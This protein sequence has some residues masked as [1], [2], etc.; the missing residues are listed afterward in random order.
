MRAS[1]LIRVSL[2]LIVTSILVSG[3]HMARA[4]DLEPGDGGVGSG[5]LAAV[6]DGIRAA[7]YRVTWQEQTVLDDLDAAWHAP[8]RAHDL[9]T[10]FTPDG[11]RIV[12]RTEAMPGWHLGL[13]LT[14][15]GGPGSI[16]AL[17]QAILTPEANRILCDHGPVTGQWVNGE[18]GLQ[19]VLTVLEPGSAERALVMSTQSSAWR[20]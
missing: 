12:P 8:N 2:A 14:G 16:Q 17:E 9:R 7:E 5:W 10:Y 4:G 6:E 11:V 15:W 20:W 13:S 3:A 1:T 19:Q 18:T